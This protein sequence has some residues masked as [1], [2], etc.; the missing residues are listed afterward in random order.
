MCRHQ[1][2]ILWERR[3]GDSS[4]GDRNTAGER[5]SCREVREAKSV[6]WWQKAGTSL[7]TAAVCD[8]AR[9][10]GKAHTFPF[11]NLGGKDTDVGRAPLSPD[12]RLEDLSINLV[13][14]LGISEPAASSSL[15]PGGWGWQ[16]EVGSQG[17]GGCSIKVRPGG[18]QHHRRSGHQNSLSLCTR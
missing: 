18:G 17:R 7:F 11:I 2:S 16:Q 4:E 10:P 6:F 8:N 1:A 5:S 15:A 14:S 3:R 13:G 12:W 9:Q